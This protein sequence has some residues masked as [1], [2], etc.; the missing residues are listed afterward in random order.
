MSAS[1]YEHQSDH[2]LKCWFFFSAFCAVFGMVYEL[3]SHGVSSPAMI[4]MYLYP[5]LLGVIPCF[6]LKLL[7]QPM[8]GRLWQDGVM[9]LTA[10]SLIQ[11]IIEIYGTSAYYPLLFYAAGTVLMTVSAAIRLISLLRRY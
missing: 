9:C 11:G 8:P 1:A 7:K 3:F 4:W 5:F 10:G 6:V 2:F